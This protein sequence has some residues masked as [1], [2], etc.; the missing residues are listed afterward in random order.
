MPFLLTAF[1]FAKGFIA[2]LSPSQL[3]IAALVMLA[4]FQH[5]HAKRLEHHD[6]ATTR[7][8]GKERDGHA[9]DI[10]RW[11]AASEAAT[12]L[13]KATIARVETRQATISQ[14][15]TDAYTANLAALRASYSRMRDQAANHTSPANGDRASP[16]PASPGPVDGQALP[17]DQPDLGYTAEIELQL[18]ALIDWNRKQAGIDPNAKP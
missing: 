6:L 18:N 5:I 13:N 2:K 15:T 16:V 17:S 3:A 1:G 4:V 7:A 10:A 11:K 12:K 8:L 14:E 9:A